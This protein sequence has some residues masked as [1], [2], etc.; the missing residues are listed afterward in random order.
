MLEVRALQ[1]VPQCGAEPAGCS[2]D[3]G[4]VKTTG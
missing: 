1:N 3:G 2:V 4:A